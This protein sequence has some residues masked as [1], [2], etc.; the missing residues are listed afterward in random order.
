MSDTEIGTLLSTEDKNLL[1][2][3]LQ[4]LLAMRDH[5]PADQRPD[6]DEVQEL[7]RRVNTPAQDPAP[8]EGNATPSTDP[9]AA[10]AAATVTQQAVTVVHNNRISGNTVGGSIIQTAAVHGG[11]R[12]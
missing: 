12:F 1:T 3:G 10:Q 9:A 11:I 8:A 6:A 4:L 2:Q 7:M 5:L